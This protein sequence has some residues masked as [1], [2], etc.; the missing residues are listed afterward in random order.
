M[1]TGPAEG[2]GSGLSPEANEADQAR[3][4]LPAD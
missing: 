3:A 4:M 1:K 2:P